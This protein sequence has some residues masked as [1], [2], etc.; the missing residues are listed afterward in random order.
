MSKR[1]ALVKK[2]YE[3]GEWRGWSKRRVWLAVGRWITAEE[4]E[5]ITGEKYE[6]E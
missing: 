1:F 3:R 5:I 6:A 2:L 4:Y